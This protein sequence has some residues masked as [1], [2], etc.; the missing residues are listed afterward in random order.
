MAS[1]WQAALDVSNPEAAAATPPLPVPL[2]A[3][4]L[5][6][7]EAHHPLAWTPCEDWE[8]DQFRY[9]TQGGEWVLR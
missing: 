4:L 9:C 2:P 6:Y 8:A 7:N 5:F 1:I 3:R